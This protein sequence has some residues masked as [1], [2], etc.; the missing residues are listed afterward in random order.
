MRLEQSF[1]VA[2]PVEQ[3]WTALVDLEQLA[4]CLAGAAITGHSDDGT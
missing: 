4:A 2:A 1:A 3:V